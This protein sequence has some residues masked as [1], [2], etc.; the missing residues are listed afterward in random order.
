MTNKGIRQFVPPSQGYGN[1]WV[2]VLDDA[3]KKFAELMYP[4]LN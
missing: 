4:G 1:D 2:L 3:G